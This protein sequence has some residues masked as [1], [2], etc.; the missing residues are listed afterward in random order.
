MA[1][2]SVHDLI[3][4]HRNEYTTKASGLRWVRL[5]ASEVLSR[6]GFEMAS[7]PNFG[8]GDG[9]EARLDNFKDK[10]KAVYSASS[11][12]SSG[13]FDVTP[14]QWKEWGSSVRKGI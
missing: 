1:V 5:T 9:A 4:N 13:Y 3:A 11:A 10:M 8:G 6:T 7:G 2:F 14:E 12:S